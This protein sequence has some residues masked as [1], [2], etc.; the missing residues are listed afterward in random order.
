MKSNEYDRLARWRTFVPLL[1]LL[2]LS[3]M[4]PPARNRNMIFFQKSWNSFSNKHVEDLLIWNS[5]FSSKYSNDCVRFGCGLYSEGI[6]FSY[7]DN[8]LIRW[9]YKWPL[10]SSAPLAK[11]PKR[12]VVSVC[13]SCR[14]RDFRSSLKCLGN[15]YSS[16]PT[17]RGRTISSAEIVYH[18]VRSER[19]VSSG[20]RREKVKI[21]RSIHREKHPNTTNRCL[22]LLDEVFN[23]VLVNADRNEP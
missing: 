7:N 14:T 8:Q 2:L 20:L 5:F 16:Q 3:E 1:L 12:F 15:L 22:F 13:K 6:F 17:H 11:Q 10:M 23:G 4:H 18:N 9:K 19:R 21:R